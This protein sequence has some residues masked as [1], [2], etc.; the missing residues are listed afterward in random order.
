MEEIT[1]TIKPYSE[2]G[3]MYDIYINADASCEDITERESDDGG[4]CTT[5]IANA[6]E[7]ATAQ[8]Q[9]LIKRSK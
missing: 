3:Y 7:M 2:G 1:I 5:T 8:A 6:L 9:D 4:L